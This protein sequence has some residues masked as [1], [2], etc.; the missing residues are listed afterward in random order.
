MI[1]SRCR[2]FVLNGICSL[3]RCENISRLLPHHSFHAIPVSF[4]LRPEYFLSTI[5]VFACWMATL[6]RYPWRHSSWLNIWVPELCDQPHGESI[7]IYFFLLLISFRQRREM[8]RD[9]LGPLNNGYV[10]EL[11]NSKFISHI[12]WNT[13]LLWLSCY[14]YGAITTHNI[15]CMSAGMSDCTTFWL[16]H[17]VLF[18]T[19]T[20]DMKRRWT[21][22]RIPFTNHR[23]AS[24]FCVFCCAVYAL[25]V[26]VRWWY[27]SSSTVYMY[28]VLPPH[29]KLFLYIPFI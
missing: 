29:P 9:S 25:C 10:C 7:Q 14:W 16:R 18:G 28:V 12:P 2:R 8:H 21:I 5:I 4:D 27:T 23:F 19:V 3:L 13:Q 26:C 24:P 11:L 17:L 15:A 6:I 22:F 20:R 1:N